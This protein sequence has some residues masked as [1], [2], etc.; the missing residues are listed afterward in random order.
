MS[1]DP[2]KNLLGCLGRFHTLLFLLDKQHSP[3]ATTL[4][5]IYNFL[6]KTHYCLRSCELFNASRRTNSRESS[7]HN[8]SSSSIVATL[9]P[10]PFFWLN[11]PECF[12]S[13]QID[14][15][16]LKPKMSYL[17]LL[18]KVTKRFIERS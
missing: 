1:Y 11:R 12:T 2:L 7:Y 8:L 10:L 3:S 16:L 18:L 9:T 14:Q 5:P 4:F 6:L 13:Y 17:M 15:M